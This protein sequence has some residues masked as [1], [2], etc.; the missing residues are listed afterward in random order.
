MNIS[1]PVKSLAKSSASL[2]VFFKKGSNK[3]HSCRCETG[4]IPDLATDKQGGW[5]Q[6]VDVFWVWLRAPTSARSPGHPFPHLL[7]WENSK[8]ELEMWEI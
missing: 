2:W 4:L 7:L 8:A 6:A 5:F 1:L 3:Q